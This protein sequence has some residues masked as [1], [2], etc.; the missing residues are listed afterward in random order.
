VRTYRCKVEKEVERAGKK[1]AVGT[2]TPISPWIN[3]EIELK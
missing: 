3:T 1:V 2:W